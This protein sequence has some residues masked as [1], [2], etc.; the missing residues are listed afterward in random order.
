MPRIWC[1]ISGHGF[2]H[3]AQTI[4]ILN[5]LG[6]RF[7]DLHV[8]LRTDLPQQ[9]LKENLTLPWELHPSIQDIG[10]VQDGPLLIDVQK[11]WIEYERFQ[12][13]WSQKVGTEAELIRSH[14]P[15]LVVSNI[16]YLGVEAGAQSG[17][18]TVAMGSVS[19]DQVLEYFLT[20]VSDQQRRIIDQIRQSYQK[21]QLMIRFAPIIP[22]V[23]FTDLVDVGPIAGP[24]LQSTGAVRDLL[25]MHPDEKL[26]LVAFG[27]IR[28]TSLPLDK[29]EGFEG[30]RF[31][32]FGSMA[33][34]E[35]SHVSS[36][37]SLPVPFRQILAEADLIVTKPGYATIIEAVR[38]AIPVVYVRRYN[39]VDE[40]IL[41]DYAHRYGRAKELHIDQF[42]KG[43]WIE[44]LE[45]IQQ[46]PLPKEAPPEIGTQAVVKVLAKFL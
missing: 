19:W 37:T 32:V 14:Q 21:A 4:L 45:I 46:I 40:Q 2:G 22:M 23:A 12:F 43:E 11:T 34:G 36:I 3:G 18:P 15:D 29:L 33:L 28:L 42:N 13:D 39:F 8:L 24:P 31:L 26:V 5:E 1:S 16:S 38:N 7:P 35:Y 25:K 6:K 30:Y 27:G 41:V 17:I 10:C 9:F 44:A 20:Q